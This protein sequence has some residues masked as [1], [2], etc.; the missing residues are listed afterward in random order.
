VVFDLG[1]QPAQDRIL[2]SSASS[3]GCCS[4]WL[5]GFFCVWRA[6][7][8]SAPSLILDARNHNPFEIRPRFQAVPSAQDRI[9]LAVVAP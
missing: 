2:L 3:V 8:T 9:H 5:F 4:R 1:V 6:M 7:S